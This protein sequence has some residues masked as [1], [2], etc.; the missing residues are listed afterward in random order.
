MCRYYK[1]SVSEEEGCNDFKEAKRQN[2]KPEE[3][4]DGLLM[5]EMKIQVCMLNIYIR[6][7]Q[8]V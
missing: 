7:E 3:F 5:D 4:W 6:R 2:L 1:N 8:L